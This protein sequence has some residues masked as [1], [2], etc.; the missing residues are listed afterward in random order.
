M[1]KQKLYRI[2]RREIESLAN[3]SNVDVSLN[4][5]NNFKSSASKVNKVEDDNAKNNFDENV[6]SGSNIMENELVNFSD[7]T[8]SD[9]VSELDVDES[10]DSDHDD[11]QSELSEWTINFNQSNDAVNNLLQILRKY[12]PNLPNDVRTLKKT[13][14]ITLNITPMGQ[15]R[16]LHIGL[17]K[18]LKIIL[19]NTKFLE[20]SLTIDIGIDGLP[21][22]KCSSNQL[23]PILG[24]IVSFKEVFAIGI[25]HGYKKPFCADQFLRE[26][27]REANNLLE[28]GFNYNNRKMTV[29][30][31]AFICD[32]P[33]RSFLLGKVLYNSLYLFK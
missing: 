18:Q 16:Y 14:N 21:L 13:P 9:T 4:A 28:N 6:E 26:F 27:V 20:K 23:W 12:H 15:G 5:V 7:I 1:S 10:V 33:A 29:K 25:F 2:I 8:V 19:N 11:L 17:E 22:T 32:A 31:R 3:S 24:R 30:I